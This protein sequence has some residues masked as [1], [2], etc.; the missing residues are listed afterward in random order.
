VLRGYLTLATIGIIFV[1][2]DLVERGFVG[3]L[4]RLRA[5]WKNRLLARWMNFMAGLSLETVRKIGGAGIPVCSAIPARPGVL[6]VMN[7]QS[8]LDIPVAVQCLESSPLLFVTRRRYARGIP[9]V[10]HMLHL[11]ECPFV[12]P[13]RPSRENLTSL[14]EAAA[15]SAHPWLIFPEGHRSRDG[16]IGPFKKA[17]LRAI[18]SARTWSIYLVVADGFW[19]CGR[20]KEFAANVT[21]VQAKV[22]CLGPLTPPSSSDALDGFIEDLRDRMCRKLKDMR[23]P[24]NPLHEAAEERP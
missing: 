13:G 21:T 5:S 17:G 1:A 7:H 22:E 9:L 24:S 11:Y 23:E 4:V 14:H 16:S 20:F 12:D 19:R 18:L 3:P 10:S 2:A 8:L 15:K 6:L